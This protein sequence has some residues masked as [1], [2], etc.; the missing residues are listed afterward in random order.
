LKRGVP[1]HPK[2]HDLAARLAIPHA[3]AGGLLDFLWIWAAKYAPTGDVGKYDDAH[4]EKGAGWTGTPG[5]FVAAILATGWADAKN[6]HRALLHDWPAHCEDAVHMALY[7]AHQFFA[8]GTAPLPKKIAKDERA[9]L[10][11]WWQ[12]AVAARGAT[13]PLQ[14]QPPLYYQFQTEHGS[15]TEPNS[16]VT[17][18]F[19][20]TAVGTA[21]PS[22]SPSPS[23]KPSPSREERPP[24]TAAPVSGLSD[25]QRELVRAYVRDPAN[26][27]RGAVR[28]ER[29][30]EAACLTH[31]RSRGETRAD[32][33]AEVC[34]WAWR[35]CNWSRQRQ[36][37][38]TGVTEGE[39]YD[40][41]KRARLEQTKREEIRGWA[42]RTYEPLSEVISGMRGPPCKASS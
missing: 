2:L 16:P 13:P 3:H 31:A 26:G 35:E 38:A 25:Q 14:Q 33:A 18:E 21:L 36:S 39:Q 1:E 40:R 24:E 41:M 15:V 10:A 7:R 4:I 8:D 27:A 22:P 9:K 23:P 30:I 32:W 20:R 11:P 29:E 34:L 6:G 12:A 42:S 28:R 19:V 37:G 5:A 17:G